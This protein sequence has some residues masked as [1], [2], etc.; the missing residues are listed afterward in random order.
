MWLNIS[1]YF[2]MKQPHLLIFCAFKDFYMLQSMWNTMYVLSISTSTV[3]MHIHMYVQRVKQWKNLRQKNRSTF[4]FTTNKNCCPWCSLL[5][6]SYVFG[7][8]RLHVSIV[9]GIN[10]FLQN[11]SSVCWDL[12][13]LVSIP[14]AKNQKKRDLDI[15]I[16]M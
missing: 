10:Y 11:L 16:I 15:L 14:K 9:D 8:K 1:K 3:C 7:C 4:F 5:K 2:L 6:C 12:N 13:N